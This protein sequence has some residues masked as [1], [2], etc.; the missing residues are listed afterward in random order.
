VRVQ[1]GGAAGAVAVYVFSTDGVKSLRVRYR[2][3]RLSQASVAVRDGALS[4]RT[5]EY[6]EGD[7]LCCPSN[8][9]ESEL[10][11]DDGK[12]VVDSRRD[13]DGPTPSR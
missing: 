9:V 3:Q 12:F 2:A 8:L 11:W 1:S 4:F 10:R 6:D 13:V 7:E 5:A